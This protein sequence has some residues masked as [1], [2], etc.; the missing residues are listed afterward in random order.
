MSNRSRRPSV[1]ARGYDA[2][3]RVKGRKRHILVDTLGLPIAC[4]VE[5]ADISD[6]RAG[7]SPARGL[8]FFVPKGSNGFRRRGPRKP[9][10][11]PRSPALE[12][13]EAADRETTA[14]RIQDHGPDLD[15]GAQLRLA[16]P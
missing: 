9:K 3:K 10:A 11:G 1:V 8:G 2:H 14:A 13:L 6:R 7:A 5:P 16:G 15:R 4:R 12:W